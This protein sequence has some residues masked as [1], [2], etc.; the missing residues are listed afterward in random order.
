M[1]SIGEINNPLVTVA[2][3]SS[4][5]QVELQQTLSSSFSHN[6]I[7]TIVD[8]CY[9]RPSKENSI[10]MCQGEEDRLESSQQKHMDM[11]L[12]NVTKGKFSDNSDP[13]SS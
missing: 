2:S 9:A 4:Q 6:K 8:N 10:W 12:S 7:T 1:Q 13:L 5:Q 11:F 3:T